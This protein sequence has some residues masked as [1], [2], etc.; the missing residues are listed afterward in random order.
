[1]SV[2]RFWKLEEALELLNNLDSD[3]SD[4]EIAVLLSDASDENEVNT[5]EII[6][7][8][9]YGPL[10]ARS[11]DSFQF[12]LPTHSSILTKKKRRKI[13]KRHKLFGTRNKSPHYT[14]WETQAGST[15]SDLLKQMETALKDKTPT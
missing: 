3:E 8:D 9:V 1:M 10:D 4:N 6:V 14:K 15:A 13:A 11:E 12:E 7:K 2:Q 5:G